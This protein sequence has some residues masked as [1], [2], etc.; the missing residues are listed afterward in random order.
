M[1]KE[2]PKDDPRQRTDEG[3]AKQTAQPWQGN[4]EKKQRSGT[5]KS[6]PDRWQETNTHID[7]S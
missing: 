5:T 7:R 3:F 2:T 1:S 6:D 4:P